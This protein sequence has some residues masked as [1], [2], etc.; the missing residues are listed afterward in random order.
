MNSALILFASIIA[1][2]PV[3]AASKAPLKE[4]K[5]ITLPGPAG[6]FDFMEVDQALDRLLAAHKGTKTLTVLNLKVDAT[7][8][9]PQVGEAQGVAVDQNAMAYF[10]G[11]DG[12]KSVSKID[13]NSLKKVAEVTLD[14]PVDAIA[15]D[16]RNGKI[17]AA[18]DDGDHLWII[19]GKTM[20]VTG[21]IPIP[22]TPEVIQYDS[23]SNRIFLNIKSKDQIIRINPATNKTE[24]TW[25]TLPAT[26]PHGLIV[27]GGWHRLFVAGH[28][29]E[30]VALD[31][32]TGKKMATAKIADGVDQI[33]FDPTRGLI[34]SAC[35]GMISVT[36]WNRNK[37]TPIGDVP[38]PKGA[39]TIAVD[40]KRHNVWVS[41]SDNQHSYPQEFQVEL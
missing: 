25:S 20:K 6:H 32:K 31:S 18:E 8:T 10:T 13:A 28:N 14:G 9:S 41:Y 19:D 3:R 7:M 36:K 37:L 4:G 24:T 26:S 40:L 27:Y 1:A 12:E 39:H 38:S 33:A 21:T 15:F 23:V 34:F 11:N 2:S 30:L 5:L 17:Y 35:R 29:G 16:S 22:G